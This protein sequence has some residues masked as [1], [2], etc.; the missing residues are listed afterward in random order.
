MAG[1]E[2]DPNAPW[3]QDIQEEDHNNFEPEYEQED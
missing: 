3:N 2:F 1:T